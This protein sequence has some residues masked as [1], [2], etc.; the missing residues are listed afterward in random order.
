MKPATR[1]AQ[2][3]FSSIIDA[4]L[5]NSLHNYDIK[6]PSKHLFLYDSYLFVL[7]SDTNAGTLQLCFKAHSHDIRVLLGVLKIK[8]QDIEIITASFIDPD[9]AVYLYFD[10]KYTSN[11]PLN[12]LEDADSVL[13]NLFNTL[14]ISV[15]PTIIADTEGLRLDELLK[16]YRDHADNKDHLYITDPMVKILEQRI[17]DNSFRSKK[18][19]EES[20]V[21]VEVK[22]EPSLLEW[23]VAYKEC[24]PETQPGDEVNPEHQQWAEFIYHLKRII[25]S[26][27]E[28]GIE[29]D[30]T[31]IGTVLRN[32]REGALKTTIEIVV[33]RIVKGEIGIR[34]YTSLYNMINLVPETIENF[35]Y[36]IECLTSAFLSKRGLSG[37]MEE[38]NIRGSRGRSR[39]EALRDFRD[40][41]HG[42][43]CRR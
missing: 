20:K 11:P 22:D 8:L 2:K 10:I 27:V 23:W 15:N 37:Y 31:L 32:T 36:H 17:S 39:E 42:R 33:E 40:E 16:V 24:Y 25:K 18:V 14:L 26:L 34:E 12:I 13:V 19:V 5:D 29:V 35:N 38:D 1:I 6:L 4:I 28:T 3:R 21:A 41:Q 9:D 7:S 30:T 43:S